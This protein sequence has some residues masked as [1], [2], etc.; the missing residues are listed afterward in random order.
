MDRDAALSQQIDRVRGWIEA[1][2]AISVLTG[3]GISTDSGI[4]DFRGPKGLWTRNPDAEKQATLQYYLSDPE[5]RRRSW[6]MRLDPDAGMGSLWNAAPNAAH[7]ALARLERRGKLHTL[8]TQNVDGLH[9]AA[10]NS[11]ARVVEIHGSMREFMCMSCD[12]RGPI[13]RVLERVRGGDDDPSCRSCGGIL[14]M[15]AVSFGQN[16]FPGDMERAEAGALGCDL[17]L[18]IGSTLAVYPAAAVVPAAKQNGARVVIVNGDPTEMDGIA[19]VLLRGR[20]G[21]ILPRLIP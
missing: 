8:V 9:H 5:V 19:D 17:M 13:E 21:E 20:I 11:A 4:P 1:A 6:R 7:H 18:A 14:K 3:A 15:R 2:D 12:D 10:G 16:L